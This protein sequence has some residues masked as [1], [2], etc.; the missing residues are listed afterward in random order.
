[1][2]PLLRGAVTSVYP[3]TGLFIAIKECRACNESNL[4]Q[5]VKERHAYLLALFSLACCFVISSKARTGLQNS[6]PLFLIIFC[7]MAVRLFHSRTS[8]KI[9]QN[10]SDVPS[11]ESRYLHEK[12]D[13]LQHPSNKLSPT[14]C[15][16]PTRYY[17]HVINCLWQVQSRVPKGS[18]AYDLNT[19]AP[20]GRSAHRDQIRVEV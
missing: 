8:L 16:S 2:P 4:P 11:F 5:D 20:T 1:M 12:T 14:V 6:C 9:W 15:L 10:R 18:S 19:Q 3:K 17:F 13:V 7:F